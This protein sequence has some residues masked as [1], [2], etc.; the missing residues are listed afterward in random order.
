[1]ESIPTLL[2]EYDSYDPP[3]SMWF[4]LYSGAMQFVW[5][6]YMGLWIWMIVECA[7]KDPDRNVWLWIIIF[8]PMGS[9]IY[10]FGSSD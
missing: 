1:M 7:R 3:H 4:G 2:A 6:V 8:V 5:P 9:L 10:F